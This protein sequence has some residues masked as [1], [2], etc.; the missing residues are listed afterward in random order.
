MTGIIIEKNLIPSPVNSKHLKKLTLSM[1]L[2]IEINYTLLERDP[3]GKSKQC[4]YARV[5]H[6]LIEAFLP[7]R[8]SSIFCIINPSSVQHLTQAQLYQLVLNL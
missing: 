7:H 6:I 4:F 8:A 2:K 1:E 5:R 3:S